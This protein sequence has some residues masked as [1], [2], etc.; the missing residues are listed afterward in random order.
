MDDT[1]PDPDFD[2]KLIAAAFELVAESGWP[3][4]SVAAAATRANLSLATARAR[5]P[6]RLSVLQQFGLIADQ[7]ALTGVLT[8]G[9][10]R[11]RLFDIVMRRIDALQTHRAGMLALLRDLPTDPLTIAAL[12]PASARSAAWMLQ[13]AGIDSTGLRGTLRIKGMMALWIA[14]VRA[15]QKDDSEDLSATMAALDNAL[16]RAAQAEQTMVELLGAAPLPP[17][18]QSA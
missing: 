5:F 15:W 8:E 13:G 16:N 6:G 7:A 4:L 18:H 1:A 11:D 17:G 9:P 10:V 3:S 2:R 14:T 12:A